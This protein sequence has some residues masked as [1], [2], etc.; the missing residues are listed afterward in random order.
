[1]NKNSIYTTI[2][3]I[4]LIVIIIILCV[5]SCNFERLNRFSEK[6]IDELK[7]SI[8]ASDS[9][10]KEAE[11]HYTK[12][13]NYYADKNDLSDELKKIDR[14]LHNMIK[15]QDERLLS[16]TKTIISLRDKLD[17]GTGV[18]NEVDTNLIDITL[19]YPDK[20]K[21]FIIWDGFVN[22]L[23][24][25]Y[26]GFWKFNK[27]P[28]DIIVTEESRGLWRHRIVGPDWF[29]VDSLS[30]ISLPP[31][32]Y[33]PDIE[34]RIQLFVGGGYLADLTGSSWGALSLGLGVSFDHSHNILLNVT[35][36][37]QIGLSY[38]YKFRSFKRKKKR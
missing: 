2:I 29:I 5:F 24:A 32:E 18:V 30:V 33:V 27:L 20:E 15:S 11:G 23:T 1:M 34:K 13:V 26:K 10:T 37:P 25:K 17:E 28:I 31:K 4:L 19:S 21:P 9:L 36:N 35:T 22:R 38:Y 8:L 3:T 14:D 12:L 7:K 16:I 6:Q